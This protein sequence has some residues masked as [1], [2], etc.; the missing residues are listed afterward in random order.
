MSS[1][2][3]K[4]RANF[5]AE[6]NFGLLVGGVFSALGLWWLYREK[7]GTIALVVLAVGALLMILGA[8]L[9]RSL[10]LVNRAWMTLAEALGYVMTRVTLG[11][12]F[13]LVVTPIGFIKRLQGWDP[14]RLRATPSQ[15]YWE[16]Y[17]TRQRDPRHYEKMY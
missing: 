11:I 12:V 13:Y 2:S 5:R 1:L 7:F 10:I 3:G 14:L 17:S 8:V 9:P 16:P 4:T 15:S 6:R